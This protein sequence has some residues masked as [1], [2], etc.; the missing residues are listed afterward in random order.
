MSPTPTPA[1]RQRGT[2]SS[3]PNSPTGFLAATLA[4]GCL[5]HPAPICGERGA[6]RC[7]VPELAFGFED[8][9]YLPILLTLWGQQNALFLM[10]EIKQALCWSLP[11][12]LPWMLSGIPLQSQ[13]SN[14]IPTQYT[15][16]PLPRCLTTVP[17]PP[18]PEQN[19]ALC[20]A[21]PGS[22]VHVS[23]HPGS[24]SLSENHGH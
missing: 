23:T 5:S 8:P 12:L 1:L 13:A 15:H 3:H 24:T 4:R 2:S 9:S 18:H 21:L 20:K 19:R 14:P 11:T 22:C 17:G 6:L 7:I 10:L 16:F